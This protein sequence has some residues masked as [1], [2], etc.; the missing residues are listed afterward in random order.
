M[1]I[2]LASLGISAVS[3]A[4]PPLLVVGVLGLVAALLFGLGAVYPVV[5]V[6]WFNRK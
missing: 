2:F 6:W 1:V 5:S 3:L 4:M